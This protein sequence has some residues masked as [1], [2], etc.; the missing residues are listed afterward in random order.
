M[1][2]P[3]PQAASVPPLR[4]VVAMLHVASVPRAAAF[5][6]LLGFDVANTHHDPACGD[7]PVWAWLQT[8]HGGSLMLALAD[9]PVDPAVQA[10]LFY[11]YCDDVVAMHAALL[12]SGV[13]AGDITYPFYCPK[14]EF[15]MVDPDGYVAMV[16]HT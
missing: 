12:A 16:T 1:P 13:A 15:R 2:P 11:L 9:D 14:G 7:E 4:N 8:P 3:A 10:V 6:A 5:Y